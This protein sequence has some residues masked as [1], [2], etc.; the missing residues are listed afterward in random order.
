VPKSELQGP[1]PPSLVP[2]VVLLALA[3]VLI[4]VVLVSNPNTMP[5]GLK[6]A[7]VIAAIAVIVALIGYAVYVFHATTKRGRK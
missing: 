7:I 3:A 2:G 4:V 1:K 6:T 5:G